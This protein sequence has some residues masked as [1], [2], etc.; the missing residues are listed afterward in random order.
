M[1]E[2]ATNCPFELRRLAHS[3]FPGD[4]LI[5][6]DE[7]SA[8][9]GKG[10]N[11]KATGYG[12]VLR[13]VLRTPQDRE[14]KVT[15]H[16]A[17]ANEFGHDRRSDRA[18]EML[19]AYD[20]FERL[21]HHVR[22]I[23]VG[24][25]LADGRLQSLKD[26]G[27]MYIVTTWAEGRLYVDDLRRLA[28]DGELT[29]L[30]RERCDALTAYLAE[31]HAEKSTD[32]VAWLRA[33]RDLLGSGEG[34]FGVI[35][36][37]PA[38][39]PSAPPRRLRDIESAC[40]EWRWNLRTRTDRLRRTHGDFHPFNVVFNGGT[41][42]TTLDASRGCLG[43]PADDV[44]AMAINY[45]FFALKNP[46][47]WSAAFGPL[48]H[49]FWRG[50]LDRTEDTGL[51]DVVAPFLA[52]RALVVASPRFYPGLAPATRDSL[53]RLAERALAG[54]RFNPSWA[55]ELFP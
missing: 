53:L 36:A 12:R 30:D 52:W 35:D 20:D 15:F 24:A 42:L 4:E 28:K 8:D 11:E 25:V 38:D 49:R 34:I 1:S 41:D 43:D 21:P 16:M 29:A 54:R 45:V 26:A 27:E 46:H 3:L 47:T 33:V 14:R 37:Y 22:A 9:E 31:V 51:L 6:V 55:D 18:A 32:S 13:L 50:Y 39:T 7:L 48:W 40:D 17:S 10:A 5:R 2:T 23:D 44:T 19:L